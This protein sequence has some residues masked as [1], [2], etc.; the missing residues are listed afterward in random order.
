M[1]A[2]RKLVGEELGGLKVSEGMLL[3]EDD[4][5]IED[6]VEG[7]ATAR[8]SGDNRGENMGS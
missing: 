4:E 8:T 5:G 3:L 7:S 2:F 6:D 1:E